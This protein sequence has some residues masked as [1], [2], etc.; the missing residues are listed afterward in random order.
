M[1]TPVLSAGIQVM[2]QVEPQPGNPIARLSPYHFARQ[3]NT[4]CSGRTQ[5]LRRFRVDGRPP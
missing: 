2:R 1:K 4:R 3:F 5:P